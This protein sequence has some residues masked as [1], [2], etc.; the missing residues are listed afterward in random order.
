MNQ[1]EEAVAQLVS[2]IDTDHVTSKNHVLDYQK[3]PILLD[4]SGVKTS[5][6]AQNVQVESLARRMG[7]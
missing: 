7:A 4:L 6:N 2:T 1:N 3:P 5:T